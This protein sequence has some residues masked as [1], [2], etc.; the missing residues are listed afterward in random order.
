MGPSVWLAC[1]RP[2]KRSMMVVWRLAGE[3]EGA[4]RTQAEEKTSLSKR[5]WASIRIGAYLAPLG[6]RDNWLR[7]CSS[8]SA[9]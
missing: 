8:S 9:C 6:A 1:G 2:M 5:Q 7:C 3:L 4:A